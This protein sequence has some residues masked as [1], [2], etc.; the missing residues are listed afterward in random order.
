M[1][2][3]SNTDI[4]DIN[5]LL[6]GFHLN[7]G[8]WFSEEAKI[9]Y[10][11]KSAHIC[12]EIINSI[13]YRSKEMALAFSSW[14]SSAGYENIKSIHWTSRPGDLAKVTF[15]DVDY[16]KNPTDILVKFVSGPANGFI[17]LSAKS[18]KFKSDICFKNPGIGTIDS[19]FNLML[20]NKFRDYEDVVIA[21]MKLPVSRNERK[22]VIRNDKMIADKINFHANHILNELR[23]D[24]YTKLSLLEMNELRSYLISDWL[25]AD[26]LFPPYVKVIG[27]GNK[28]PYLAE[29]IDPRNNKK[30]NLLRSCKINLDKIG[31]S[32][33]GI[34]CNDV[35]IMKLRMKFE[36]E[37]LCSSIKF[38]GEP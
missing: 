33:I 22:E 15:A 11:M 8:Q 12:P 6:C 37:K 38:S 10:E 32:S 31:I 7:K 21:D 19:S 35:R 34:S 2:K 36:S 9:H 27:K 5:E 30:L 18:S 20:S 29:V 17:G 24:F 23:N 4:A 16:K 28:Q 3:P 26:D 13:S 1:T 14:C 25:N